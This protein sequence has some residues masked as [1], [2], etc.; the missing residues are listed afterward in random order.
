MYEILA[1]E[2]EILDEGIKDTLKNIGLGALL[3][4][5]LAGP[6]QALDNVK[7]NDLLKM[8]MT[9]SQASEI[10]KMSAQAKGE[11]VQRFEKQADNPEVTK[12]VEKIKSA[13][14]VSDSSLKDKKD[15]FKPVLGKDGYY[16][17]VDP[18]FK[19]NPFGDLLKGS[20]WE[21][22]PTGEMAKLKAL[23]AKP[24]KGNSNLIAVYTTSVWGVKQFN[25]GMYKGLYARGEPEQIWGVR[26]FDKST[27][28]EYTVSRDY[29]ETDANSVKK[30]FDSGNFKIGK[31]I[32]H[33]PFKDPYFNQA[34]RIIK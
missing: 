7:M 22:P 32:G 29:T 28:E 1:E 14:N 17:E 13:N 24:V 34:K 20:G 23:D 15:T 31:N 19:K 21:S 6:A 26:I 10:I 2:R 11:V 27:G 33:N 3:S 12:Q 18:E 25:K 30:F 9:S 16:A 8:G 4:V 5:S